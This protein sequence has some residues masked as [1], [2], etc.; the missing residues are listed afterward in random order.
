MITLGHSRVNSRR[1]GYYD[2][3]EKSIQTQTPA[4]CVYRQGEYLG[5]FIDNGG[6]GVPESNRIPLHLHDFAPYGKK[7]YTNLDIGKRN[8]GTQ[9]SWF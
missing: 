6:S 2:Y 4:G 1:D 7:H 3:I 9:L 5:R 8:D